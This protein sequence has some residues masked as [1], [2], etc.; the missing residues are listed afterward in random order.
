[1]RCPWHVVEYLH[2]IDNRQQLGATGD[3][4]IVAIPPVRFSAFCGVAS[5]LLIVLWFRSFDAATTYYG[6][7]SGTHAVELISQRGFTGLVLFDPSITPHSYRARWGLQ[8]VELTF[9]EPHWDFGIRSE[10]DR[11]L[12]LMVP[13][14]LIVLIVAVSPFVALTIRWRFSLRTMLIATTVVA[15]ALGGIEII[16]R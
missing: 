5:L 3:A 6:R 16:G 2:A 10:S 13:W 12:Q 4:Q 1:V 11:Y 9:A 7:V 14:W 15:V 8:T